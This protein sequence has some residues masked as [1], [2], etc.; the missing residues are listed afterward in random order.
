M[1]LTEPV[2]TAAS[3]FCRGGDS[4]DLWTQCARLHSSRVIIT[5]RW[6]SDWLLDTATKKKCRWLLARWICNVPDVTSPSVQI[7]WVGC[8]PLTLREWG[9]GGGICHH[10]RA[11]NGSRRLRSIMGP[12]KRSVSWRLPPFGLVVF[13]LGRQ[14]HSES[15]EVNLQTRLPKDAASELEP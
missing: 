11:E 13:E 15:D 14:C 7:G 5:T 2:A 3:W 1:L 8:I 9:G 6:P 12:Y 4:G 10:V